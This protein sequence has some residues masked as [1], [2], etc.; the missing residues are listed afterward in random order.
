MATATT[1]RWHERV[2]KDLRGNLAWRRAVCRRMAEDE[3]FAAGIRQMCAEDPLFWINGFVWTY[4]PRRSPRTK[5][6][7]IT[8]EFQDDSIRDLVAA[9]ESGSDVLLEKSRDMG[10][11]W[12][13]LLVLA[14]FWMF[15]EL[16]SFLMVSRVEAYVDDPGN[17]KSLFWKLD[18][19]IDNMPPSLRPARERTKL[20][21]RNA[22][23]GSVID[24]ESTTGEVARGDRRTAILLDEFAAVDQGHKVLSATRDATTCRIFNSTH[25]GTGTAYYKMTQ[26]RIRK[27]RLH[28]SLHPLKAVGLYTR[29]LGVYVPLDLDY[30]RGR[31]DAHAE[32]ASLDE[33]IIA[34]GVTVEDGKLRSVWYA[35]ECERAAHAVEIAQELDID[36][37]GSSYQFFSASSIEDYIGRHCGPP[38]H[39]G[40]LEFDPDTLEPIG[41]REDSRGRMR[42]WF[43]VGQNGMPAVVPLAVLGFDVSAGTGASNSAASGIN[44][45]SLEKVLEYAS[46]HIRPEA[47]GR[48]GVA[49]ARWLGNARMVWEQNGPGRQF[50]DAV[51]EAGYRNV[52]YRVD[53]ESV[54][55]TMTGVPGWVPTKDNKLALLG[56][57]RRALELETLINRSEASLRDALEYIFTTNGSVEHAKA[58]DTFDPTGARSNHGDRVIADALAWK[59]AKTRPAVQ[60]EEKPREPVGCFAWRRKRAAE[61]RVRQTAWT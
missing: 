56:E 61:S 41:W 6:P 2:P 38:L 48:Y 47:F 12:I 10:A 29:R 54:V 19:A 7:M 34:R 28:W 16:R 17:P 27:L 1:F 51:I 45:V 40:E 11:S 25:Q 13:C 36:V 53:E 22:E 20:H 46:P 35:G 33:K 31:E 26:T 24:G 60:R 57:Y 9:V 32:M 21:L 50:G 59:L 39:V 4:D 37:F 58:Q 55:K 23:N 8:Y 3:S 30:W 5:I 52:Y 43:P 49:L 42:L 14:W 18:F 15:R 44:L